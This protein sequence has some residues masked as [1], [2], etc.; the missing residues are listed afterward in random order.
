MPQFVTKVSLR[1]F[2]ISSSVKSGTNLD[3]AQSVCSQLI[4]MVTRLK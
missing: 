2:A 4:S 3:S 1:M